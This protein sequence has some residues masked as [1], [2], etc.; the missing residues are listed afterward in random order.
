MNSETVSSDNDGFVK[1]EMLRDNF[2]WFYSKYEVLK[3]D[4]NNQYIAVRDKV[5]I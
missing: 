1:F 5:Q 4:F 3:R 2:K